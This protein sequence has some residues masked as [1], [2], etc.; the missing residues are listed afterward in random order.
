MNQEDLSGAGMVFMLPVSSRR[1]G[2]AGVR[3]AIVATKRGNARRAKGRRK[4]DG[5]TDTTPQGQPVA[6]LARAKQAGEVRVRWAWVEAA[7]WTDRVLRA[8]LFA[9]QGLYSLAT[10]HA[11]ARQPARR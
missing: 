7:V 4:V 6:V 8:L 9:G 10:A 1:A 2:R 5:V 11:L 3:A